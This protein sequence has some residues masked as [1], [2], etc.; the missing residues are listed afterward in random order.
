MTELVLKRVDEGTQVLG[1]LSVYKDG[2]RVWGCCTTELPWRANKNNRSCIPPAPPE[3]PGPYDGESA[4]Y[5]V[6]HR[7]AQDSPSRDYDHLILEGVPERTY[8]LIHRGNYVSDTAGCILVGRQFVDLDGDGVT[9]ITRSTETLRQ[10]R[11]RL[12]DAGCDLHIEWTGAATAQEL[13]EH[14]DGMSVE[15]LVAAAKM[16]PQS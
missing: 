14:E 8:I 5:P 4:V 12:P 7:S 10:L 6:R 1:L 11:R 13:I 2:E 15:A 16:S 9:D 3:Q